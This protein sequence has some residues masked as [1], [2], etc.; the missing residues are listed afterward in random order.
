MRAEETLPYRLLRRAETCPDRVFARVASDGTEQAL[1]YGDL[2]ERAGAFALALAAAGATVGDVV[3]I[4]LP[5]STDYVVAVFGC[6]RLGAAIAPLPPLTSEKDEQVRFHAERLL[7]AATRCGSR[8]AVVPSTAV[9][10]LSAAIDRSALELVTVESLTSV[11]P[12]VSWLGP[13][14]PD[15]TAV[16]QFSSGSTSA[17]KGVR[18]TFRNIEANAAAAA[19][20]ARISDSDAML[21]FLPFFHDFGLFGGI[22]YPFVWDIPT[23]LHPTEAFVRRP[24]FW[25][26]ALSRTRATMCP[27]PQFVYQV[28]LHMIRDRDVEGCDLSAWRIA[29]DGGEPVHAATLRAF[30]ERFAPLGLAPTTIL[31]SYGMAEA[32]LAVAIHPTGSVF[33]SERVS[34][35][36]L[37]ELGVARPAAPGEPAV[38]VV[39]CGP[40]LEGIDLSIL[41]ERGAE[42]RERE[43]GEIAIRGESVAR[44]YVVGPRETEPLERDG[45]FRTGDLGYLVNGRLFV[46]GRVKDVI[47]RGGRNYFPQDIERTIEL[48]PGVR[49]NGVAAFGCYD[50]ENGTEWI[51]A[52][53][54]LDTLDESVT[55]TLPER[56]RRAVYDALEL[57]LDE[58]VL[59]R[60][61]WI[62]KTTSGKLQRAKARSLY[63]SEA[64]T[65]A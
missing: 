24:S 10:A 26:K 29:Y 35:D 57:T 45:W 46:T 18:I 2:A 58:V 54:E 37:V 16:V 47:I 52:A 62:P 11:K 15:R 50:E 36:G 8:I 4:A 64:G 53:I 49:L 6:H 17:P 60:R 59:R 14:H 43:V 9:A 21:S 44:E 48:L 41:T 30:N 42:A 65:V 56:A 5:T 27:A 61:G 3:P 31:P 7:H 32:T 22:I 12:G 39:S 34:R 38:E 20:R 40:P 51:V 63:L 25:L 28:A 33:E 19:R 55:G 13:F 1:T 23:W